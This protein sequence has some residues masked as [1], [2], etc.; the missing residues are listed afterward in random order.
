VKNFLSMANSGHKIQVVVIIS[1]ST[2][3]AYCC[4]EF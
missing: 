1:T 2:S 4:E 3:S